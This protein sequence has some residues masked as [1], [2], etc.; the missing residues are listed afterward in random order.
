M[1]DETAAEPN[2]GRR[3]RTLRLAEPE[4]RAPID[5]KELAQYALLV[6]RQLERLQP[7]ERAEVM[8]VAS[9]LTQIDVARFLRSEQLRQQGFAVQDE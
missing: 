7:L 4:V 1:T 2:G 3:R 8:T 9:S 6:V 5:K